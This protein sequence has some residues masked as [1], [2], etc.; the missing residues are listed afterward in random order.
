MNKFRILK[1]IGFAIA[2]MIFLVLLSF[3]EVAIY[4]YLIN[5]GQIESFYEQHAMLTA[6]YISGIFG[7]IVFY[8]V[9]QYWTRK[10]Y[11]SVFSLSILYPSIY[12]LIDL[13]I[14]IPTGFLFTI[15]AFTIFL[16]ANSAKYLG[17]FLGYKVTTTIQKKKE[18]Q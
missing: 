13:L 6:P 12:V 10:Q 5:P 7:F 9:T 8:L 17:S 2:T 15:E 14:L 18:L 16:I 1:L 4:S 11:D 3:L